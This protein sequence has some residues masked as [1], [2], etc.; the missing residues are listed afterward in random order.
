[1]KKAARKSVAGTSDKTG[2]G[3][4]SVLL[5]VKAVPGAKRD[6]VVGWLGH[7]LKVRV[8]APPEGGKA[9]RAICELLANEL[10]IKAR[11][12]EV[13]SGAGSAEKTVR[14]VGISEHHAL[15]RWAT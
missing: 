6:E 8:S 4:K 12:V 14:L 7:R 9:N 15:T 13:V 10:G 2:A 11:D 3:P 5:A 1:M